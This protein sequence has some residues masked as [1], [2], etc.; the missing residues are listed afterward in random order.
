MTISARSLPPALRAGTTLALPWVACGVQLALWDRLTGLV[1]FLFYP[2]VFVGALL[3]PFVYSVAATVEAAVLG[4]FCFVPPRFTWQGFH[5]GI[6][7]SVY[8]F[9]LMGVVFAVFGERLRRAEDASR[10]ALAQTA[11]ANRTIAASRDEVLQLLERARELDVA[12]SEFFA[13]V[14]HE[15]R[16]PL[17]LITLPLELQLEHLVEDD[18]DRELVLTAIRNA[19]ILTRHVHNLLE[20][21][22]LASASL[23]VQPSDVDVADI[24][25][26]AVAA[27][28]ADAA[29][30]GLSVVTET[31]PAPAHVDADKVRRVLGHLLTNAVSFTPDGGTVRVGCRLEQDLV[32]M[33]VADS[34]PGIGQ[35]ER[36]RVFDGFR[37]G[38]A[39]RAVKGGGTGMGLTLVRELVGLMGGT[40]DA[41]LAPE[42]GA[43][44]TVRLPRRSPVAAPPQDEPARA[45]A[46]R[47][48]GQRPRAAGER[49]R[50][51]VVEDNPDLRELLCQVLSQRYEMSCAA[52]GE[53]GVR[54]ALSVVPDVVVT[55][56]MMPRM[57]G[58]ELVRALRASTAC[59][60]VPIVVF[61]ALADESGHRRLLAAGADAYVDKPAGPRILVDRIEALLEGA[62]DTRS[63]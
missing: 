36:A 20:A 17:T 11:A 19:R 56:V 40:V 28:R 35:D 34:G 5:S 16:T 53:E 43:L 31:Q 38:S 42:G 37:T 48:S 45:S 33:E 30:R 8:M 25:G 54:T 46:P 15:L 24:V 61:S 1:W 10:L 14:S 41:A 62:P 12:K 13:N 58:E 4:F 26:S 44:L 63:A 21:A 49:P 7:L 3:G 59:S 50:V 18:P 27:V 47:L 9:T 55:D 22:Q 2:A 60:D 57:D 51:L 52:D 23:V 29:E 32:V 39:P 6:Q